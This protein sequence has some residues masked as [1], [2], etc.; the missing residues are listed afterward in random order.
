MLCNSGLVAVKFAYFQ[1]AD[2]SMQLL[3]VYVKELENRNSTDIYADDFNSTQAS[4]FRRFSPPISMN[5]S[6]SIYLALPIHMWSI[7]S[8]LDS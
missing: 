6:L 5:V 1:N 3:L 7:F 4:N 8:F 2:N